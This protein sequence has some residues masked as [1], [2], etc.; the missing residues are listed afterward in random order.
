LKHISIKLLIWAALFSI[1]LK[2]Q[3]ATNLVLLRSEASKGSAVEQ[4]KLGWMEMA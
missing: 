1:Q 4:Y 2:A 3:D